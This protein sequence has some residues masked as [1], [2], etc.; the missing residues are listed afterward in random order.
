MNATLAALYGLNKT[1]SAEQEE[2]DLTTISGA[3]LLAG[4][5][6][7]EIVLE[8]DEPGEKTAGDGDLDLSKISGAELLA[9]LEQ[10]EAAGDE[11]T[12]QK[13]AS[14]G[15]LEYFDMAGRI[16]AHAHADEMSKL[17]GEDYPDEIEIDMN[18]ISGEQLLG[19]IEAGYEF[20]EGE[21]K[22]ARH[23]IN[24]GL[25]H[26][27]GQ[28]LEAA[29]SNLKGKGFAP[30]KRIAEHYRGR[31]N[32]ASRRASDYLSKHYSRGGSGS[33]NQ[34]RLI[35]ARANLREFAPEVGVGA[36]A[37]TAGGIL[38]KRKLSRKKGS[39]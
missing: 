29:G 10:E 20:D 13:M 19:L 3:E 27:I 32:S 38:A 26:R 31:R 8:G 16:M 36:T 9:L 24:R 17:A 25:A 23:V 39:K 34:Q 21:E 11:E 30:G 4:I 7:G 15:S 6:S 5:E 18:E 35:D 1:A 28:G 14:D 12:L 33:R 2:I 22:V 37:L